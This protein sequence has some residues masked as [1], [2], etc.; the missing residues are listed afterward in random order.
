MN[1]EKADFV[2]FRHQQAEYKLNQDILRS[3]NPQDPVRADKQDF[4]TDLTEK[5]KSEAR[6][7]AESFFNNFDPKL[8]AFLFVSSDFVRAAET[9][10]IY[11]EVAEERGFDIITPNKPG[12]QTV[13]SVGGGK[14]KH[15]QN[16]SLKIDNALIDQLFNHETDYLKLAQERGV[17][18]EDD[19]VSRWKQA[20]KIIEDDNKGTWSENWRYHS[21][22]IKSIMPEIATAQEIFNNQFRNLTRLMK[23][24]RKKIEE[25]NH[26][27][28]IRV[29][30]FT[31]E[32]L[33]THWLSERWGESGLNPGESVSFYHDTENNLRANVRGAD[34]LVVENEIQ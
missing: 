26:L 14:I 31:H 32:N 34:G 3:E 4:I 11:L 22:R 29:L 7:Q 24:G 21:G 18:F 10:K 12:S 25:S 19:L 6:L 17:E 20:R 9:A 28:K 30:A 33:F 8:D 5:G 16:L 15:L 1:P 23:F 13:E 2:V 27:K